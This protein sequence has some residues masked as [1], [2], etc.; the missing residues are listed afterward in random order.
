MGVADTIIA[1][2]LYQGYQTRPVTEEMIVTGI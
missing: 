2:S 1:E